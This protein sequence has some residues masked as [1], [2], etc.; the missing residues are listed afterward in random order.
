MEHFGGITAKSIFNGGSETVDNVRQALSEGKP[1][2]VNPQSGPDS[3]FTSGGHY[4]VLLGEDEN[5]ALILSD[6][7]NGNYKKMGCKYEPG[8]EEFVKRYLGGPV[9]A[10]IPDQVP[11]GV[12]FNKKLAG[13]EADLEV[14]APEQC[15]VTNIERGETSDSITIKFISDNKVKDMTMK[16]EGI[17]LKDDIDVTENLIDKGTVI[18]YTTEEDIKLLMRDGKKAIINNIEDYMKL[19]KKKAGNLNGSEYDFFYFTYYESGK[20]CTEGNGPASVGACQPGIEH[21]VG[22]CQWTTMTNGLSNIQ[23]VC[24]KL[25]ELDS[26]LCGNLAKYADM[27][28]ATLIN[29][30][31]MQPTFEDSYLK[32]DFQHI[33]DRD[34]DRFLE[35]QMQIAIEEK[36]ETFDDLG[37]SWIKERPPVVQGTLGSLVNWGP[38]MGW[39]DAINESMSDEE[40]IINLLK[41]A[42]TKS[43][44]VGSL[45][46]R[47]NPQAKAALDILHGQLDSYKL[48]EEEGFGTEYS[49]G[50]QYV[51]F[52]STQ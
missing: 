38:Y 10:I 49:T 34:R 37:L 8:L 12:N 1:V 33:A 23:K 48:L 26:N 9:D 30:Y 25:A 18:G 39:E 35:L 7:N 50:G 42:C 28:C 6:P 31:G 27:D 4:I 44:T 32:R 16:I 11:T 2:I 41:Y 19:P 51:N 14:I 46:T 29:K 5:G 47:W 3:L 20:W 13:F 40:I 21:G 43:S 45:N 52:L 36:Y 17:K 22:I 15:I 24:G